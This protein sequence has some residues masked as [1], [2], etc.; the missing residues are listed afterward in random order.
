[1]GYSGLGRPYNRWLYRVRRHVFQRMVSSLDLPSP[2]AELTALDVGSG[3]GFYIERW[4]EVGVQSIAGCD[5]TSVSIE[6]LRD[7]FPDLDFYQLD[8]S[9]GDPLPPIGPFDLI[10]AFDIL[11][12]IVDDDRYRQAIYNISELLKPGGWFLFSENFVHGSAV[13]T[14]HVVSRPAVEIRA[15][16]ES[17]GMTV[18]DQ[19]PMFVLMNYPVDTR[20]EVAG[21]L[22]GLATL[23]IRATGRL[24]SGLGFLAGGLLYPLELVLTSMMRRGPSTEVAIARKLPA[25]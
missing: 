19:R 4:R 5:L 16:L 24:G 22:W 23:P 8:V 13:R 15:T 17:V 20:S 21:R 14:P 1:M 3:T 11:F 7:R 9:T 2:A 10:S 25:A 12:H 18:V 6:R